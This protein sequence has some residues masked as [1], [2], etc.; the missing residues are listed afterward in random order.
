ML[1][2]KLKNGKSLKFSILKMQLKLLI[3]AHIYNVEGKSSI[4]IVQIQIQRFFTLTC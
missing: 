1:H 4:Q 3:S 2:K